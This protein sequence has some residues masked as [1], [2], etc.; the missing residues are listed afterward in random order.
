M[1]R[2]VIKVA[3]GQSFGK[4]ASEGPDLVFVIRTRA[5]PGLHLVGVRR[6]AVV[7]IQTEVLIIDLHLEAVIT[8]I[9][10]LLRGDIINAL[11]YLELSTIGWMCARVKTKVGIRNSNLPRDSSANNP[12]LRLGVVAIIYLHGRSIDENCTSNIQTF[13]LHAVEMNGLSFEISGHQRGR[14]D[15][16]SS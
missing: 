7:Q 10:P 4:H 9:I 5:G 11:P 8:G 2:R 14:K 12:M 1:T 16:S 6:D 3:F 15:S 13:V